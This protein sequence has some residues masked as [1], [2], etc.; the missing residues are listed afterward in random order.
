MDFGFHSQRKSEGATMGIRDLCKIE[1]A[2]G[3]YAAMMHWSRKFHRCVWWKWETL[4]R[5]FTCDDEPWPAIS[6]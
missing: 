2:V 4:A 6:R 1:I 3:K 5:G